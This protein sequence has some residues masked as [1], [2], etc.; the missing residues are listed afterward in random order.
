MM[1][2]SFNYLTFDV[3]FL[4]FQT[5]NFFGIINVYTE[6]LVFNLKEINRCTLLASN[7]GFILFNNFVLNT[8]FVYLS[9]KQYVIYRDN[10]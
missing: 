1:L 7:F 2:N 10:A 5:F 4:N 3:Y 8:S 9:F 6:N